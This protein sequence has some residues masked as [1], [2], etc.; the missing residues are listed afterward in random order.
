[1]DRILGMGYNGIGLWDSMGFNGIQWCQ[2]QV[3]LRRLHNIYGDI[4]IYTLVYYGDSQQL[5]W[6]WTVNCGRL[7]SGSRIP[8]RAAVAFVCKA[9]ASSRRS[10][11]VDTSGIS[12]KSG[13]VP[14]KKKGQTPIWGQIPK[15]KTIQV[16]LIAQACY[17]LVA[18]LLHLNLVSAI[19]Q[20]NRVKE[21]GSLV[22]VGCRTCRERKNNSNVLC[23]MVKR[24]WSIFQVSVS[25]AGNVQERNPNS[26]SCFFFLCFFVFVLLCYCV[27]PDLCLAVSHSNGQCATS[28]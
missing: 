13:S 25:A 7:A 6:W 3:K 8:P 5:E 11:V 28:A 22:R 27:D 18:V 14:D 12:L 1:M 16:S 19:L 2:C 17:H 23:P 24:S 4:Y 10:S 9:A 21:A 15:L 26:G 20:H